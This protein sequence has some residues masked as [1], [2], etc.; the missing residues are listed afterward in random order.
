M[1]VGGLV[2]HEHG[3]VDLRE[4]N[5]RFLLRARSLALAFSL[6]PRGILPDLSPSQVLQGGSATDGQKAG[7]G[8]GGR[9]R[10]GCR[11]ATGYKEEA[12]GAKAGGYVEKLH[13]E[14]AYIT[15]DTKSWKLR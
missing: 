3:I 13:N 12:E 15:G 8:E 14:L 6:S 7:G 4:T 10:E 9:Q 11:R 1:S 2:E 5:N